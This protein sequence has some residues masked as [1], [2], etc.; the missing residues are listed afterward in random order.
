[1]SNDAKLG[2]VLGVALV[3]LIGLVFFQ[4]PEAAA[5]NAPATTIPTEKQR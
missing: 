1:M 5:G 4:R 2:L 3:I